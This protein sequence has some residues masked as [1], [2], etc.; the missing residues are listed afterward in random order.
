MTTTTALAPAE[1]TPA[2]S[3]AT[4]T[5]ASASRG[6][7]AGSSPSRS[8]AVPSLRSSRS[9]TPINTQEG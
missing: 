6:H 2:T 9:G 8:S 5:Q 7:S 4:D 3:D 1:T